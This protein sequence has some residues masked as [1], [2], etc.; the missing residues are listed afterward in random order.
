[1][2]VALYGVI[3]GLIV[4][5]FAKKAIAEKLG[6]R[7]GRSVAIDSLSVNPYTL[8]ATVKGL[9]ILEPN[10]TTA[11]AS[12]DRLDLNGS[13]TS[14]YRLAPV[15]DEVTLTGLKVNLVR[16]GETHYNLTDILGRLAAAPAQKDDKKAEFSLSNI[17]LVNARVDFDDR[18]K[19]AKHQVTEIDVAI[20]F[21]SNLPTHLKEYVQPTFAAKVNGTPLH[22]TGET[23]PFENSL[24]TH[25]A[26][27]LDALEIHRYVEYSPTALPQR[28]M[29]ES[30]TPTCRCGSRR[31][32][33]R[34]RRS[35]WPASSA[36]R[37]VRCRCPIEGALAIRR[38][39]STSPH[40]IPLPGRSMSVRCAWPTPAPNR[41]V[42]RAA[43]SRRRTSASTSRRRPCASNRSPRTTACSL[44]ARARRLD[45]AADAAA[46]CARRRMRPCPGSSRSASSGSPATR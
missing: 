26:I 11:F 35:T 33:A 7:I 1:M 4:P 42:A 17:R 23:L 28:S 25:V 10:G 2:A 14:V 39:T 15:A 12:F 36:L 19:G 18:P 8:N 3:V 31:R 21:V 16:D 30:S 29:R 20:P 46:K 38:V 5:P 9:R 41:G 13:I 40:S 44:Q 43:T 6:E 24:R 37:D 27:D 34:T 22:L 45:R 32:R